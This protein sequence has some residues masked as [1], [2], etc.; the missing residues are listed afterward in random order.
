M[1]TKL[2]LPIIL[3]MFLLTFV[4]AIPQITITQDRTIITETFDVSSSEYD[5]DEQELEFSILESFGIDIPEE[6]ETAVIGMTLS[7]FI[8]EIDFRIEF[9]DG[10]TYP[11]FT[12]FELND[13]CNISFSVEG[14][15]FGEMEL[16]F[17]NITLDELITTINTMG[18]SFIEDFE[19]IPL[20]SE[21]D[22]NFLNNLIQENASQVS[23]VGNSY[24]EKSGTTYT[25]RYDVESGFG[26]VP[27]E[28]LDK[29]EE[30]LEKSSY[31]FTYSDLSEFKFPPII[32]GYL[33]NYNIED[34]TLDI[35]LGDLE[36]INSTQPVTYPIIFELIGDGNTYSASIDLILDGI[37]TEYNYVPEQE[38]IRNRVRA[39]EGLQ[40][41]NTVNID[42]DFDLSETTL[43]GNTKGLQ[44]MNITL[45]YSQEA[46]IQFA[47][48]TSEVTN[49]NK[50]FLY[51]YEDNAWTKLPTTPLGENAGYYEY[52]AIT[53]HFSLFLIA[54]EIVEDS[55]DDESSSSDD[56]DEDE[57]DDDET[58][59][60]VC[61]E[62]ATQCLGTNLG[63]C[64]NNEWVMETCSYG[65]ENEQCNDAPII[66]QDDDEDKGFIAGI[67][68]AIIGTLG[69]GGTIV[70]STLILG[71]IGAFSFVKIKKRR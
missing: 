33:T 59:D 35:D 10:E 11:E 14:L 47:I 2:L 48:E 57:E 63:K 50:V 60:S 52:S 18:P 40:L 16:A 4:C 23:M 55:D 28:Y 38:Q 39:I 30:I 53:P 67:T 24:F 42:L 66:V 6:L 1:S 58:I 27:E 25:M 19:D 26:D 51:V 22:I 69:T 32:Q 46:K 29:I 13:F 45:E 37:E 71:L 62:G 12:I 21:I 17:E 64:V 31:L 44:L 56:E 68:G 65:C 41:G 15:I 3:G 54:E 49:P 34:Y 7:E 43:P 20:C 70:I 5:W 61:T 9:N 8:E 36:L